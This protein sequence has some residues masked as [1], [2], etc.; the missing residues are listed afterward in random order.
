[1]VSLDLIHLH[2]NVKIII[3]GQSS[4]TRGT[5]HRRKTFSA[6]GYTWTLPGETI[7]VG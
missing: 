5:I 2:S 7:T 1:M 4:R 6:I 3:V